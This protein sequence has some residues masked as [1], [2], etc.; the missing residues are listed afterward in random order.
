M[1][2]E[3][4]L[5][6][7]F[8]GN[9]AAFRS[10]R[11]SDEYFG[12]GILRKDHE[13][14][15]VSGPESFP[16]FAISVVLNGRGEYE[17]C[18]S[19]KRYPMKK[20]CYFLRIPGVRHCIH[21]DVT[22]G[23]LEGFLNLGLFAFPYFSTYFGV[24]AEH[25]V[26]TFTPDPL[27]EQHF[28]ELRGKLENCPEKRLFQLLP[29]FFALGDACLQRE[30]RTSKLGRMIDKSCCFLS[31]NFRNNRDFPS[32]CRENGWGYENLR[33]KFRASIGV[34]PGQYRS[35]RRMDAA[36][37]LLMSCDRPLESIAEE[38]GFCS[39][40]EFSEQFTRH[41]GVTPAVFRSRKFR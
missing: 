37:A 39:V 1:G 11:K 4:M 7:T 9:W 40:N 22:S 25:P 24:S 8:S 32:F 29:E 13:Y 12:L 33:K 3:S 30:P 28:L 10:V 2:K 35:Q 6:G 36:S 31:S 14:E 34:S 17:D 26:G 23:F 19:G 38:L 5:F 16:F 41:N 27:W 18:H 15:K 21:I 20:G